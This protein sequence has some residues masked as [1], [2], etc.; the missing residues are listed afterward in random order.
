MVSKCK[1]VEDINNEWENFCQE[2]EGYDEFNERVLNVNIVSNIASSLNNEF[3][4]PTELYISTKTTISYLNIPIDLKNVFWKIPVL[5]Y[6]YPCVGVVKKQ[7]KFISTTQE[8]L[9][10]ILEKKKEYDYVDELIISQIIKPDGR[11]K[12]R[13][14]RKVSIGLCRKDITSYRCKKKSAFMNC[15]V[16]ILRLLYNDE[17]KEIHVKIFNTGKLEIP[18]IQTHDILHKVLTLLIEI[19][20]PIV[21]TD[22]AVPLCFLG[23]K[24]ETVLINSNFSCGYYINRDKLYE[25]LKYKYKLNSAYDPCSYPGI[26][27]EFYYNPLLEIQTG[28]QPSNLEESY[29]VSFMI[30][31]TGSVL[32][33]GK[34]SENILYKIYD[35]LCNILKDEYKNVGGVLV[36]TESVKN[37]ILNK[38]LRKTRKKI[39][40]N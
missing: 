26:Q 4:I 2:E 30:F 40:L 6:A 9:D 15:F 24:S 7:M 29:K 21:V 34:C 18:G 8:D 32:I 25:E 27:C 35:F 22:P 28:I 17:Y 19:L 5:T 36:D 33:V 11:I 10:D 38:K 1:K 16:V 23:E 12:F 37:E 14:I 3:P 20:T 39:I 13:D 31:R